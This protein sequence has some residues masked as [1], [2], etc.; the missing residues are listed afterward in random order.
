MSKQLTVYVITYNEEFM[1]PFFIRQYRSRF[2]DC[3]IVVCDNYSTDAT[4]HIAKDHNCAVC[5]YDSNNELRDDYFLEIKNKIWK[6]PLQICNYA[7]HVC[8]TK[9]CLVVDC[10]EILDITPSILVKDINIIK[11]T[12]YNMFGENH[13]DL[14]RI[15]YGTFSQK[16]CK[17]CC[18]Q[19]SE[20][21]AINYSPGAHHAFPKGNLK[22]N[23]FPV[24]LY[25]Y[26]Y[27]GI[28]YLTAKYASMTARLSD[29]NKKRD[30]S[31]H[32][33]RP[34]IEQYN[35]IKQNKIKLK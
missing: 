27:I 17:T 7:D 10:D 6:E 34:F 4:V 31:G 23:T 2:S 33:A 13:R 16:Y 14:D 29:E 12:G 35:Q 20:I 15:K 18:W 5:Y 21:T 1:L 26:H 11:A 28:E 30:W 24:N 8:Q 25:H 32:Y 22:Y 19:P 3:H 9:W